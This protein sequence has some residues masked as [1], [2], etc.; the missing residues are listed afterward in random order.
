MSGSIIL[1]R[2]AEPDDVVPTAVFLAAPDSDYVT[3]QVMAIDG[4]MVLV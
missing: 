3:G 4:G 1:G 2:A